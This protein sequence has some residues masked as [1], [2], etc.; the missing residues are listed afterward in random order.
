M[1]SGLEPL[2]DAA[3]M[4]ATLGNPVAPHVQALIDQTL[5]GGQ[6]RRLVL[7]HE[8]TGQSDARREPSST[9]PPGRVLLL[10]PLSDLLRCN[11]CNRHD[12]FGTNLAG[13]L[14]SDQ[15]SAIQ[16]SRCACK[17]KAGRPG[18]R[19]VLRHEKT[20]QVVI[21]RL[22]PAKVLAPGQATS[23]SLFQTKIWSIAVQANAVCAWKY[24][25]VS[26]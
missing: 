20:V 21:T 25:R 5:T 4:Q 15:R 24:D 16:S 3:P 13:L 22:T 2:S 18:A 26:G 8:S 17:L 9:W 14:L 23:T 12:T 6:E 11:R 19:T 10:Q 7:R 1:L